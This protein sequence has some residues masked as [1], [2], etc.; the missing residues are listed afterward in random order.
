MGNA[1]GPRAIVPGPQRVSPVG[2]GFGRDVL[3]SVRS[4]AGLMLT[5]PPTPYLAHLP[6]MPT[7]PPHADARTR[8]S[9][10]MAVLARVE[11]H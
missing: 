1:T 6:I 3:R 2:S 11:W 7:A 9:G 10:G 8:R 4:N 5:N